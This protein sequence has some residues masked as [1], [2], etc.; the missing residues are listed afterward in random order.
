MSPES[1]FKY[2]KQACSGDFLQTA[3]F[4]ELI[5]F[6]CH[7]NSVNDCNDYMGTL[8]WLSS[9]K[10]KNGTKSKNIQWRF[11]P[12]QFKKWRIK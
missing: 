8:D 7:F 5:S 9:C 10:G 12:R 6:Q 1:M 3:E 4:F 2:V 11:D